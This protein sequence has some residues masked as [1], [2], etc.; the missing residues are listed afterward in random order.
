VQRELGFFGRAWGRLASPA[1][2]RDDEQQLGGKHKRL[3]TVK[4]KNKNN[5]TRRKK[6]KKSDKINEIKKS[7]NKFKITKAIVKHL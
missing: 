2:A 4:N 6:K 7:N 5:K 1:T 3:N